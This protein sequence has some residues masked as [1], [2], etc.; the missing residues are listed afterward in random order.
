MITSASISG[1]RSTLI[2]TNSCW[3]SWTVHVSDN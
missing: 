2:N 1:T 3:L